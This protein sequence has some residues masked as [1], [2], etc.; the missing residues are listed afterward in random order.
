MLDILEDTKNKEYFKSIFFQF[1]D[2][3]VRRHAGVTV[4][5]I[6]EHKFSIMSGGLDA[7]K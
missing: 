7:T 6:D 2:L 3:T 5:Y 4:S 1:I